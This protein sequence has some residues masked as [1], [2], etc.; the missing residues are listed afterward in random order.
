MSEPTQPTEGTEKP[1]TSDAV[2]QARHDALSP[3]QKHKNYLEDLERLH[4]ES[5]VNE[6]GKTA[7]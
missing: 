3:E 1:A 6:Y 4:N 7:G 2:E 5:Q